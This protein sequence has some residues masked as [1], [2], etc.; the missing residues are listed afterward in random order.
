LYGTVSL[1]S[2]VRSSYGHLFPDKRK[3]YYFNR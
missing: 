1:I 2:P 3:H